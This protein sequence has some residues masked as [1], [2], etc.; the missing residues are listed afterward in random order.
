MQLEQHDAMS[1]DRSSTIV[2]EE[3]PFYCEPELLR[4]NGKCSHRGH[5][6]TL[7]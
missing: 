7:R 1:C 5:I 3:R 4:Y 2:R 6:A